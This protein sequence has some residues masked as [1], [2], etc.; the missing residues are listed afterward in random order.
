MSVP[1]LHNKR[2]RLII[3]SL[4]AIAVVVAGLLVFSAY[5]SHQNAGY[6]RVCPVSGARCGSGRD[7]LVAGCHG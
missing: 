6:N 3:I 4:L 7:A 5:R 1:R 2:L